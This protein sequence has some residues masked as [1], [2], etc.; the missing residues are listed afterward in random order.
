MLGG[1]HQGVG[2]VGHLAVAILRDE[3]RIGLAHTKRQ[4]PGDSNDA[5]QFARNLRQRIG[6]LGDPLDIP[7]GR[8]D[9]DLIGGSCGSRG[10]Q[11]VGGIAL[12]QDVQRAFLV[13]QV[14]LEEQKVFVDALQRAGQGSHAARGGERRVLHHLDARVLPG[15]RLVGRPQMP[16]DDDN[17]PN[18]PLLEQPKGTCDQRFTADF[19]EALGQVGEHASKPGSHA[20]S[21]DDR[22]LG[23]TGHQPRPATPSRKARAISWGES[24]G[25]SR[26]S[27]SRSFTVI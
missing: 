9:P 15:Q 25:R 24:N 5:H 18:A 8:F 27:A 7:T 10:Q 13:K 11:N 21:Q 16:R 3:R 20:G 17:A 23:T 19:D 12:E 26:P 6:R 4:G 1:R 2:L 14:A 22:G